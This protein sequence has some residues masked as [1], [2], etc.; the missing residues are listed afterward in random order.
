MKLYALCLA[1][2]LMLSITGTAVAG[3]TPRPWQW[4]PAKAATKVVAA[5]PIAFDSY[6][7]SSA[8]CVG[9]GKGIA[10]RYSRFLCQVSYSTFTSPLLVRVLAIGTGKL[11]VVTAADGRSLPRDAKTPVGLLV[12]PARVCP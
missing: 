1:L 2:V 6:R 8:T 3:T 9:K 10:G 12:V 7:L 4:K 5:Q 11:C